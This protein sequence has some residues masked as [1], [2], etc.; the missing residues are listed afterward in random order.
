MIR[1]TF[2]TLGLA[3]LATIP[4]HAQ[5]TTDV[6]KTV[7]DLEIQW[8]VSIAAANWTAV[9]SFLAPEY[10]G[11]DA[12]GKRMDRAA[13]IASLKAGGTYSNPTNGT[14]SVLVNGSTAVHLGEGTYTVTTKNGKATRYH[15]VWTDTWVLM[16][17]GQWLCIASQYVEHKLK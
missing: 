10:M 8:G 3:A 13:Y 15:Q 11:T 16:P 14:Y 12:T 6:A 7:N 4:L 1:K 17:N 9:E 2:L 5:A